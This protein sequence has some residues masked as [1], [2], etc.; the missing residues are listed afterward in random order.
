MGS[1]PQLEPPGR[2]RT[3][4][5]PS[6]RTAPS[7]PRARRHAVPRVGGVVRR[8]CHDAPVRR[9]RVR[10]QRRWSRVDR[11]HARVQSGGRTGPALV[12]SDGAMRPMR[13]GRGSGPM[14]R[15]SISPAAP[16][17]GP[18]SSSAASFSRNISPPCTAPDRCRRRKR[19]CVTNSWYGK[20]HLEMHW[21]HAAHFA[22]VGPRAAPRAQP[23]V[24]HA[25]PAARARRSRGARATPARAGRRWW[26]P[27]GDRRR[28]RSRVF[29]IWQQP[30]PIFLAELLYRD[31]A[32]A[33]RRWPVMPTS[34]SRPPSSWH[35]M[36]LPTGTG[37]YVLG[38][39]LIPAQESYGVI[40]ARLANPTFE[41]A[42]WH[43]GLDTAQRWL[44]AARQA[45]KRAMGSRAEQPGACRR[46]AT[47][48]MPRLPSSRSPTAP[49]TRR[50]SPR[51]ACC[52]RR[53]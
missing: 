32:D 46:C 48:S 43:W 23:G 28:A 44:R 2:H 42:Y 47:A 15:R 33:R 36:P 14:V 50:C 17:P 10:Y 45:A 11:A 13:I 26:G 6:E 49:I 7:S 35:R 5:E 12:R 25:D 37:R 8:P 38:P 16:T 30:H 22:L 4:V 24:V 31:A 21:W 20:L 51:S 3:R 40:R 41:L 53:R 27:T 34:S 19:V 1:A 29:L 9:S 18:S 39:P 52:R